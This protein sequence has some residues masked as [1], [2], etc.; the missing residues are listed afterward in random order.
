VIN[1]AG[2]LPRDLRRRYERTL[3]ELIRKIDSI[4]EIPVQRIHGD[5]YGGN[6]AWT[7]EGPVFMDLDDFQMGPVALDVKL[8][9]FPWKLDSLPDSLGRRER[10]E[11]QH[12]MVLDIYRK[13][14]PF[15]KKWERLFPLLSAYRDVQFD[16]WFSARWSD[17]GFSEYYSDQNIV[18]PRWW[19]D[20]IEG[21]EESL[22]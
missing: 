1:R 11:I 4:G 19:I 5:T 14:R 18:D 6:V 12:Q 16:A 17:T 20:S 9:S 2:Y 21:L 7:S 13:H 22:S 3:E 15:Q 10:R 8:L